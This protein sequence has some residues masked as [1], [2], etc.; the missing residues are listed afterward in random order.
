[1]GGYFGGASA[2]GGTTGSD[3]TD[4]TVWRSGS[5]VPADASGVDGDFYLDNDTGNVYTKASGVYSLTGNIKGANGAVGN[6]GAQG[7]DVWLSPSQGTRLS[8]TWTTGLPAGNLGWTSTVTGG[9]ATLVAIPVGGASR[10]GFIQLSTGT[11]TTGI[12]VLN[13]GG[14]NHSYILSNG[15]PHTFETEFLSGT[16]STVTDEYIL[17]S[18]YL[19]TVTSA[20]ATFGVWFEYDRL[21]NG[22]FWVIRTRN[23]VGV[24]TTTVTSIPVVA[25]TFYKLKFYINSAGTSVSYYIN[26]ALA[27]TITTNIPPNTNGRQVSP[28]YTI[29]KSAGTTAATITLDWAL[30]CTGN[31]A[32]NS[33]TDPSGYSS[34][35][36]P[37]QIYKNTKSMLF[38]SSKYVNLGNNFN[39]EYNQPWSLTFWVKFNDTTAGTLFSKQN[40]ASST[41]AGIVIAT[42][43]SNANYNFLMY[44]NSVNFIRL[45]GAFS[46][47]QGQWNNITITYNG[48][49]LVSGVRLYHQGIWRTGTALSD[50]LSGLSILNSSNA[51]I[52]GAFNAAANI[53]C[54]LNQFGIVNRV[55]NPTEVYEIYNNQGM[56]SLLDVIKDGSLIGYYRLGDDD[57]TST[58]YDSSPSAI[59]GTITGTPTIASDVPQTDSG[60]I[61]KSRHPYAGEE[62]T[63]NWLTGGSAGRNGWTYTANGGAA[64]TNFAGTMRLD[65]GTSA[66]GAPT[67]V[68]ANNIYLGTNASFLPTNIAYSYVMESKVTLINLST[69]TEEYKVRYGFGL[70]TASTAPTNGI[71]FEYD[72]LT[73]VNWIC[74]TVSGGVSTQTITTIP[75]AVFNFDQTYLRI[76]VDAA[77]A[78]A[79]FKINGSTVATVSTN[80]PTVPAIG[81]Y[82]MVKSAGTTSR[83]F[84]VDWWAFKYWQA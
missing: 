27:G 9:S 40:S 3:G 16:L 60:S 15:I 32:T 49:G 39:F 82:H 75:V 11:T 73:S 66:T 78:A 83:L 18:G 56:K 72:R 52:N 37:V 65:T 22:N 68:L 20:A 19:N 80:L 10:N 7:A 34:V 24:D 53:A 28:N 59:T 42:S 12:S 63:D 29:I 17:R 81:G 21:T 79:V 36:Q 58:A 69:V 13:L 84:Q 23:G 1:M 35:V 44:A 51:Y 70:G 45:Q 48:S 55:L 4:G 25:S 31:A 67:L 5:G 41:S 50:T 74:Y 77:R 6:T 30:I 57:T 2:G 71:Y 33:A 26:G 64:F 54:N 61:W 43:S 8:E 14:T 38:A 46:F 76:E 62:L 47:V